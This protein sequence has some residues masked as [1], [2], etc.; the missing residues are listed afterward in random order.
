[1]GHI[2]RPHLRKVGDPSPQTDPALF[3][4]NEIQAEI[5]Y[6]IG[7]NKRHGSHPLR[8]AAYMKLAEVLA[9]RQR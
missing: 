2:Y 6:L 1:M 3:T 8:T 9:G 4:D 5:K 7:L